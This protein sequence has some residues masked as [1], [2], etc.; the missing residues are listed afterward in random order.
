MKYLSACLAL[1]A[2]TPAWAQTDITPG[3]NLVVQGMPKIPAAL[4]EQVARYT[5]FR[6]AGLADWHPTQREMLI[7]TRFADTNQIHHVKFP[8]GDRRQLTFFADSV[9]SASFPKHHADYFLFAKGAGGNERYQLFRHDP[10]TGRAA[11]LTDGK[12]RNGAVRW[13][14]KD[15]RIV[16]ASTRRNGADVD[17]Y[18]MDPINRKTD[19]LLAKMSGGGWMPLDWSP[20]ER[21]ILVAEY[22]SIHESYRWLIDVEFGQTIELTPRGGK[23]KVSYGGG[24]FSKDGNGIYMTSDQDS[25]FQRLVYFDLDTRKSKVLTPDI[26][27]DIDSFALSPEGKLLAFVVNEDGVGKLRLW[28]TAS[29]KLLPAPKLP[30]GSVLGIQW[31]NNGKDLGF[32]L[33]SARSPADVYS[34]DVTSGKVE[35]WTHSETGGLDTR[36]FAEPELIGW[37]SFDKRMISGF[38]YR[39]AAKFRG[40]RP[41]VIDIHGGPES[42]FRPTFLARK[43]YLLSELGVALM[44]PNI[45]GSSGYGKTFLQLDNGFLREDAYKD[46][47]ALLDWIAKQPDLD[48]DRVLVTGGS[49]GGH[50]TLAVAT[51]YPDRIRCAVDVVG[52]SNLATLLENTESYR[53]DLRRAEYGDEREPKM[54][55]FMNRIAPVNNA[56]KITRPLFVIQGKNDPRVPLSEA[57]QMVQA[58]RKNATPVWYLM[59]TDEGHGFVKKKNADFQF[60]ATILFMEQFLLDGMEKKATIEETLPHPDASARGLARASGSRGQKCEVFTGLAQA[61]ATGPATPEEAVKQM[62]A[63][64]QRAD[65]GALFALMGEQ[66]RLHQKTTLENMRLQQTMLGL[67]D[68]TFDKMP[69]KPIDMKSVLPRIKNLQIRK[70]DGAGDKFNLTVWV[71]QEAGGEAYISEAIWVAEKAGG[72]WKLQIPPAGEMLEDYKEGPDGAKVEVYVLKSQFRHDPRLVEYLRTTLPKYQAHMDRL[73]RDVRDGK[74]KSREEAVKAWQAAEEAFRR[75]NPSPMID[76]K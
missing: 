39:P 5:E 17:L 11:L 58:V 62:L 41:V 69:A 60:Y 43:N 35:R 12:S 61:A 59:A 33:V 24:E 74:Y 3:P 57:E 28:H 1:V 2:V 4:A 55:A 18:V 15:D 70:K 6:S 66:T 9:S 34:F 30:P 71:S 68:E 63:A 23:E 46:I 67:L 21:Y 32:S 44:C 64:F 56:H 53:R 13:S 16:Y 36:Q 10:A 73:M 37:E 76:K 42:Q 27:W 20:G 51:Y 26:P 38:L 8:G 72:A 49:Y 75:A 40:R 31:H 65:L 47:G 54:R 14:R 25:E 19:R 52:V 50:M 22:V 7:A 48:P 29:G 45:R